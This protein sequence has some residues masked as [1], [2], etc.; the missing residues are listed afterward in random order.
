MLTIAGLLVTPPVWS[1]DKPPG[2]AAAPTQADRDAAAREFARGE[3]AFKAGEF[4]LA[5]SAFEEAYRLAP[6]HAPLWNAARA[7]HRAGQHARAA[8]LY[9]KYLSEAPADAP[10]REGA[11]TA[12]A[13][14]QPPAPSAPVVTPDTAPSGPGAPAIPPSGPGAP[15]AAPLASTAMIRP[16]PLESPRSGWSPIVVLV[17]GGVTLL[18]AAGTLWS[19]VDAD[20][21]HDTANAAP[22]DMELE[23]EAKRRD[24][25]TA[26]VGGFTGTVLIFTGVAAIW[27]VDWKGKGKTVK[28]SLGV[29]AA[30]GNGTARAGQ[31]PRPTLTV[32]GSF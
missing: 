1:Q 27:L 17:G 32:T 9:T 2:A 20:R 6:H 16:L 12:L 28:A 26:I 23:K 22:D 25:R 19:A 14:L 10:D 3:K 24:W 11:R 4:V 7:W 30:P 18:G 21:V 8:N 29:D 15:G 5:A 31:G 13:E